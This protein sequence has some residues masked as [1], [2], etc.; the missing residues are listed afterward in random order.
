MLIGS[1]SRG[2]QLACAVHVKETFQNAGTVSFCE[3]TNKTQSSAAAIVIMESNAQTK[4]AIAMFKGA[5]V[6]GKLM[7]V[8]PYKF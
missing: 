1:N 6:N 7:A 2:C 4:K 3:I 5:D 8:H